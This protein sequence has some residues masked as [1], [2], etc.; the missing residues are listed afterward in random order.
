MRRQA[1]KPLEPLGESKL[2]KVSQSYNSLAERRQRSKACALHAKARQKRA[3][4]SR[5]TRVGAS[6]MKDPKIVPPMPPSSAAVRSPGS[7]NSAPPIAAPSAAPASPPTVAI[8]TCSWVDII[9]TSSC[10]RLLPRRGNG[11]G[12]ADAAQDKP[13]KAANL[14]QCLGTAG[15]EACDTAPGGERAAP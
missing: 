11:G 14:Q 4:F 13:S 7:P 12:R 3:F 5:A 2:P 9:V 15:L 10:S 1:C 6:Y 8:V